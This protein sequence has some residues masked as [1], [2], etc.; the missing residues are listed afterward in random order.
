MPATHVAKIPARLSFEGGAAIWTQ[1]LTAYGCLIH[2]GAMHMGDAVAITAASSSVGI[3]A[4]QMVN[5]AGGVTIAITRKSEKRPLLL[6]AGAQHVIVSE[7]ENL[8]AR[9]AEITGGQGVRIAFTQ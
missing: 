1:Y 7:T 3:A 9:V 6:E 8:T 5:D 4:I 2:F